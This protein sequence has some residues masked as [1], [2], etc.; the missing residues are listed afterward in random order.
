MSSEGAR[1]DERQGIMRWIATMGAAAL[2]IGC[3]SDIPP[4]L[5]PPIPDVTEASEF[6][7]PFVEP[8]Y[9]I[10]VGDVLAIQS[11]FDPSLNQEVV[12]RPDGRIS[13]TLV[14]E[15]D[16]LGKTPTELDKELTAA[17]AA[18]LNAPDISVVVKEAAGRSVYV[19]GEVASPSLLP[20]QGDLTLLQGI[21]RVGWFRS[22][23]N[24]KQ[25]LLLRRQADGKFRVFQDNVDRVLRNE[26]P[27][28]YLRRHDIVYVPKTQ[29]ADLNQFVT[30]YLSNMVP[31]FVRFS[32]GYQFINRTDGSSTVTQ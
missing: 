18:Y 29:I 13:L 16:V 27:D 2:L 3:N 17:Y 7:S 11:Y 15:I 9:R 32:F 26:S 31:D 22:T 8:E 6:Y 28:V 12:V 1:N 24:T 14:D 20:L 5:V 21:A 25:V 10:Q 19:G 23:G 4:E 30:Q